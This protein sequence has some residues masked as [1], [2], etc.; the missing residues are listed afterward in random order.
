[1]RIGIN[2]VGVSKGLKNRDWKNTSDNIKENLINGWG[3]NEVYV[4]VTTYYNDSIN[5]LL[6]FYNPINYKILQYKNSDQRLTYIESLKNIEY[7]PLDFIISTR[8]DIKFKNSISN[9]DIKYDK[10]NFL[11]KEK[12]W[13]DNHNFVTDNIFLFDTKYTGFFIESIYDFYKKPY[14]DCPDLHPTYRYIKPKIGEENINIISNI[15]EIS[16]NNSF[17]TLIRE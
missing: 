12:G 16:T 17:Y 4:Y 1:M 15:E 11:F 13:W 2:L 14:R 10:F 5:E 6:Y 7:E 3:D 9:L 8:F